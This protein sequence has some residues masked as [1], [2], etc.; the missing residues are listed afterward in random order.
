M[1]SLA[2]EI[3]LDPQSPDLVLRHPTLNECVKIWTNTSTSWMDSLTLPSYLKESLFLTKVPLARNDG[4]TTWILVDKNLPADRRQILSSCESFRKRSLTSDSDGRVEDNIVHGIASVFCSTEYRGRGYPVRMMRELA[5]TLYTWQ[6]DKLSCAGSIL[7]SDIGK[8]YYSKL[9]WKPND[10]NCHIEFKSCSVPRSSLVKELLAS[11]LEAL[12]NRDEVLIRKTMATPAKDTNLRVT[13][14][15]D[16]D[17]MGWH[18]AKED[19]ACDHLFGKI[20]QAKGAIA[21]SP[22]SQVWA[23]W[24]HRYY[25]H[26]HSGSSNN[27]LYILRLVI[28][29]DETAT[30]LPTY[31][32]KKPTGEKYDEQLGLLRVVLQAAQSEATEW[33]L[34]VVKLWN[35]TPLVQE[36]LTKTGLEYVRMEREEDSIASGLWY[37]EMGGVRGVAPLWV[38]NEHYAW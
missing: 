4:M 17:H 27:V 22:G 33:K 1:S 13:I 10:E 34:D 31:R 29:V 26:P 20:A 3:L 19:F 37:D 12:C 36:M 24:T 38:N 7:Y 11:D 2:T 15:P 30:R 28:E 32:Q 6:T 25:C 8:T 18:L 35:P 23:I 5:K 14:I 9:G 16:L 21:G